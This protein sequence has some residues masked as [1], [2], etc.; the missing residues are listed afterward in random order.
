MDKRLE[1]FWEIEIALA[2]PDT[3]QGNNDRWFMM[4]THL[5]TQDEAESTLTTV[6]E[7]YSDRSFRL[8]RVERYLVE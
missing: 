1:V 3:A 8:V 2:Q 4:K 5:N 6:R 7:K